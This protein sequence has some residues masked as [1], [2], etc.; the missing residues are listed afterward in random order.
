MKLLNYLKSLFIKSPNVPYN[1][2][3]RIIRKLVYK[4]ED[5]GT[6]ISESYSGTTMIWLSESGVKIKVYAHGYS[7]SDF[8][9]AHLVNKETLRSFIRSNEL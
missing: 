6:F 8:L 5:E 2:Y 3:E 4:K 7:E 9:P 1:E